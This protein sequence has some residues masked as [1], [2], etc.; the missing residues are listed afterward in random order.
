MESVAS[1]ALAEPLPLLR[2]EGGREP[3][4]QV[5]VQGDRR[6]GD[7]DGWDPDHHPRPARI[8]VRAGGNDGREEGVVGWG[9]GVTSRSKAVA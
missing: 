2:R 6:P 3:G 8:R 7:R 5:E 9:G 1:L 4:G